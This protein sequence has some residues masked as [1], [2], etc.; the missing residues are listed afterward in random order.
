[1]IFPIFEYFQNQKGVWGFH[2]QADLYILW[3]SQIYA[4]SSF[5][6]T[7]H[8]I[9]KNGLFEGE[10]VMLKKLKKQGVKNKWRKKKR[11]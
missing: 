10:M 7:K 1:M 3:I 4:C 9:A 8:I 5:P 6:S 2:R 11:L